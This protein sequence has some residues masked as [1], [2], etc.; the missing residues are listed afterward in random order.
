MLT[1]VLFVNEEYEIP[2]SSLPDVAQILLRSPHRQ[3]HVI[4]KYLLLASSS[5]DVPAATYHLVSE[6]LKRDLLSQS[7]LQPAI[8]HLA[9]LARNE[10]DNIQAMV[11]WGRVLLSRDEEVEAMKILR[12]V[13]DD[14][15]LERREHANNKKSS[16]SNNATIIDASRV[17]AYLALARLS[18]KHQDPEQAR[19][20]YEQAAHIYDAVEAWT[21]LAEIHSSS[22]HSHLPHYEYYLLR[23]AA[24]GS[25][26]AADQLG[27]FYRRRWMADN[28]SDVKL[29]KW[30]E[31]WFNIC[32]A[33]G[34]VRNPD[35]L[36]R[37]SNDP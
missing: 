36:V 35:D 16:S 4:A 27:S 23:A 1:Y 28:K 5:L 11:L 25:L 31:E 33:E 24:K 6:G 3:H 7:Q 9:R 30:S 32:L 15:M 37:L 19:K 10:P 18:V 8:K 2:A 29:L 21:Y 34:V 20:W 14:D 22:S 12:K 17:N 13:V 26:D